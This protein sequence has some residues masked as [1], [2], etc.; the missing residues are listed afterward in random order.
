MK[1]ALP[2]SFYIY[3]FRKLHHTAR[4]DIFAVKLTRSIFGEIVVLN[5]DSFKGPGKFGKQ[6]QAMKNAYLWGV[7]R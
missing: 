2:S 3:H 5:S 1:L 7:A 4:K 6:Y